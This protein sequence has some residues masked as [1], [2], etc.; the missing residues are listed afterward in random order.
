MSGE[1]QPEVVNQFAET[2]FLLNQKNEFVAI[3]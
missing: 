2:I 1:V 3:I